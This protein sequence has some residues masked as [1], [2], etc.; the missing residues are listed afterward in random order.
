METVAALLAALSSVSKL[1][2]DLVTAHQKALA[3]KDKEIADLKQQIANLP[4]PP[5]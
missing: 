2:D 5:K 3:E 1:V 4:L